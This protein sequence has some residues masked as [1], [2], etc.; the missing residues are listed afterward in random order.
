M[1]MYFFFL[2]LIIIVRVYD[3]CV[4]L[5]ETQ[6]YETIPPCLKVWEFDLIFALSKLVTTGVTTKQG[7]LT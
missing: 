1:S 7:I 6:K 4:W 2:I 3:L 5:V